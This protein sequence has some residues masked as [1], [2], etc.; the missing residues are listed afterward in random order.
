LTASHLRY[1]SS[2]AFPPALPSIKVKHVA[3]EGV[4]THIRIEGLK[5]IESWLRDLKSK[6][7]NYSKANVRCMLI[8]TNLKGASP[9]SE[10]R[11]NRLCRG[12]ALSVNSEDDLR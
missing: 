10:K 11:V 8:V 12:K 3:S 5:R 9:D 2:E 4:E 6:I 7:E 1:K